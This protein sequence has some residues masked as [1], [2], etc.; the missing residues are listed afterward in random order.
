MKKLIVFLI[1]LNLGSVAAA[2]KPEGWAAA[3]K[4][5][6]D[7]AAKPPPF[8]TAKKRLFKIYQRYGLTRTFYCGCQFSPKTHQVDL[9]TCT[10]L[11]P[12]KRGKQLEWEHLVPASRIGHRS[13]TKKDFAKT[14]QTATNPKTCTTAKIRGNNR[15]LGNP[16]NLVPS[17]GAANVA[18]SN[19]RMVDFAETDPAHS[20]CTLRID[21]QANQVE[22][23][24]SL[25]GRVARAY[26]YMDQSVFQCGL[27]TTAER[28]RYRGWNDVY[29]ATP[30]EC[31]WAAV[32]R[33]ETQVPNLLLK[34]ACGQEGRGLAKGITKC[35]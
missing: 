3:P 13:W 17:S 10:Q 16:Y 30:R 5:P 11:K 9:K 21:E 7:W 34:K 22:P 15:A 2:E 26:L 24:D 32:I 4:K 12:S 14:C 35:P 33:A 8:T 29:P 18:R 31:Y 23:A 20:V 6:M 27:L 25:K 19:R 28:T 1:L